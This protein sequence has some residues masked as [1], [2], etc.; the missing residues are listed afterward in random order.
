[1]TITT[2]IGTSEAA[3]ILGKSQA[4]VRAMIRRGELKPTQ[5]VGGWWLVDR[6]QVEALTQ[7]GTQN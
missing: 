5:K 2:P 1:M 4:Q 6:A 3:R 7:A